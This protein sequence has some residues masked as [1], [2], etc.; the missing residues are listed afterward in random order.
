MKTTLL[1]YHHFFSDFC[2]Y[3]EPLLGWK[4][5][6][7][8]A[9]SEELKNDGFTLKSENTKETIGIQVTFI[10]EIKLQKYTFLQNMAIFLAAIVSYLNSCFDGNLHTYATTK[11]WTRRHLR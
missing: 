2:V 3:F 11:E 8:C 9:T 1:K 6:H 10:S 7:P 4:C 5:L